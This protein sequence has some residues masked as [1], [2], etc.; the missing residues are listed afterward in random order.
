MFQY[1]QTLGKAYDDARYRICARLG[2][3]SRGTH[4]FRKQWAA[5]RYQELIEAGLDDKEARRA[6]TEGL[7]H[8][9]ASV[10]RH[11]LS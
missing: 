6:V 3:D 1:R 2:I 11:Y 4:G 8:G 9:R 7:G 10:L 5:E